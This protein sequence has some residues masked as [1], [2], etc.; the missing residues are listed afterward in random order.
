MRGPCVFTG[1]YKDGKGLG[2]ILEEKTKEAIDQEGWFH[3]GDIGTII[4]NNAV[5]IIDRKKHIFKMQQGEYV[6]PEK[7]ENVY[8]RTCGI[9]DI[10]VHGNSLEMFCVA[11]VVPN[12][13]YT[14]NF[15]LKN[16]IQ[17]SFQELC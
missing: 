10:F 15:G 2:L 4:E 1:Y 17:G 6:A 8:K 9:D 16:Q 5:R 14:E 12:Q 11:I 13:A 3:S 7:I